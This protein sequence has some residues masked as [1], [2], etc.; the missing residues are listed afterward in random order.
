MNDV[1]RIDPG[2]VEYHGFESPL[3]HDWSESGPFGARLQGL[4]LPRFMLTPERVG[5]LARRLESDSFNGAM[6][7]ERAEPLTRRLSMRA[8]D[9]LA[10]TRGDESRQIARTRLALSGMS[11]EADMFTARE[12]GRAA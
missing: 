5:P 12:E 1:T 11:A 9:H 8:R 2:W 7:L 6:D 3:L 4:T 10:A